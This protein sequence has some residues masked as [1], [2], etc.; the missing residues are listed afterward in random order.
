M[1]R[2]GR[3]H[4]VHPRAV[5]T[6]HGRRAPQSAAEHGV[7]R[8]QGQ[9]LLLP[10]AQGGLVA[11]RVRAELDIARRPEGEVVVEHDREVRRPEGVRPTRAAQRE[12]ELAAPLHELRLPR[13]LRGVRDLRAGFRDQ[14]TLK[15]TTTQLTVTVQQPTN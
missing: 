3:G 8:F 1:H 6:A 11:T 13:A 12:E 5:R 7:D 2:G 10:C 4:A 14:N 15:Y 9:V